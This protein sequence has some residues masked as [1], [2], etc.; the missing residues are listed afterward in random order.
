M[1]AGGAEGAIGEE[2]ELGVVWGSWVLG[3]GRFASVRGPDG[4]GEGVAAE[5]FVRVCSGGRPGGRRRYRPLRGSR[6]R[7][8]IRR[9][10]LSIVAVE[11]V[12]TVVPAVTRAPLGT[13]E[14]V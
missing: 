7:R 11:L 4:G 10:R 14:R 12:G 2:V 3:R 5:I 13:C 8:G 1:A 6:S 9:D